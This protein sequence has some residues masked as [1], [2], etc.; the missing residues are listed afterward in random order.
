ME[1]VFS[2]QNKDILLPKARYSLSKGFDKCSFCKIEFVSLLWFHRS[3]L[4]F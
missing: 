2:S 4:D 1:F 3:Y